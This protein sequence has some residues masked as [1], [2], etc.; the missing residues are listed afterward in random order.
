MPLNKDFKTFALE[1]VRE[2]FN[3]MMIFIESVRDLIRNS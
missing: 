2:D 1:E 3:N